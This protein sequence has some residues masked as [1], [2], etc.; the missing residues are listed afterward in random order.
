MVI[1]GFVAFA[2]LVVAVSGLFAGCDGGAYEG[3]CWEKCS[4]ALRFGGQACGILTPVYAAAHDCACE[5]CKA[6]CGDAICSGG[7]T[8]YSSE[9]E[10][11]D[12]KCVKC[13]YGKEDPATGEYHGPCVAEFDACRAD[14][15]PK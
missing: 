1:R 4:D 14:V 12:D 15:L 5:K 6:A 3:M 7:P 11:A 13:V 9:F 10:A 8:P 2:V